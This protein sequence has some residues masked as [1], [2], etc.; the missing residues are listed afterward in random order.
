MTTAA[1]AGAAAWVAVVGVLYGADF[2]ALFRNLIV[3]G[4]LAGTLGFVL[5]KVLGK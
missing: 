1:L 3:P 4:L 5:A 2:W